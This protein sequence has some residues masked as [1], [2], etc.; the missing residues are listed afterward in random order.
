MCVVVTPAM[1]AAT[2]DTR[3]NSSYHARS[4]GS[5]DSANASTAPVTKR[6]RALAIG[7]AVGCDASRLVDERGVEQSPAG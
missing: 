6:S 3:L 5:R 1:S 2:A 4:I 7:S